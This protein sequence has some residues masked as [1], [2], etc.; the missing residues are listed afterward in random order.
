MGDGSVKDSPAH[1]LER[2]ARVGD[3]R[4]MQLLLQRH[5]ELKEESRIQ[6]LPSIIWAS[7]YGW[8]E[9]VDTLLNLG[10]RTDVLDARGRNALHAACA[11]GR[12]DVCHRLLQAGVDSR[13]A[14]PRGVT[15]VMVAAHRG[16]VELVRAVVQS[17][18][19]QVRLAD[20]RGWTPLFHAVCSGAED[21]MLLLIE[22]GAD[23]GHVDAQGWTA[24]RHAKELQRHSCGQ[25]LQVRPSPIHIFGRYLQFIVG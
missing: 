6:S 7:L 25:I 20:H 3:A 14:D 1:E 23:V 4:N 21:V 11:L 12:L 8:V 22:C 17:D 13:H 5:P 19:A 24:M 16:H 15:A 2:C 10:C 18:P 9:L